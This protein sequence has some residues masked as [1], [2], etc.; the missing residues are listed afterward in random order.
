VYLRVGNG[1]GAHG[2]REF[3][4]WATA[5]TPMGNENR[6]IG[7]K[8]GHKKTGRQCCLPVYGVNYRLIVGYQA[9]MNLYS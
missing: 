4:G 5:I 7:E 3:H 6:V 2:Q 8:K 1:V 9:G